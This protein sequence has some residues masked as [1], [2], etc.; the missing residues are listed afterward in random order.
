MNENIENKA[1]IES[2]DAVTEE[3]TKKMDELKISKR[4]DFEAYQK[5]NKDM[6]DQFERLW[7]KY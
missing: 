2:K 1:K 5:Q 3:L 7:L 6:R 4:Q